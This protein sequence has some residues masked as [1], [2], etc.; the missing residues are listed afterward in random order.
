MARGSPFRFG[1]RRAAGDPLLVLAEIGWRW[2][3][4]AAALASAICALGRLL[5]TTQLSDGTLLALYSRT[6]ILIANAVA[7][8]LESAWPRLVT[9]LAILLPALAVL[10]TFASAAGRAATLKAMLD[11]SAVSMRAMFGL[12]FLRAGL[13]LAGVL[14][15]VGAFIVAGL[16][17]VRNEGSSPGAFLVVFL[18]LS[19][20]VSALWTLL[21]WYLSL[22]P[23][24]A[25]RD[26]RDTL[27]A[28]AEA[29][30]VVRRNRNAFSS[31]S[32]AFGLL[33]VVAF[34]SGTMVA[35]MPLSLVGVVRG[36]I[37][38]ALMGLAAL[39]YFALADFL[40]VARLAA[41]VRIVA[42]SDSE[43]AVS[44]QPSAISQIPA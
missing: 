35:L 31:V 42:E 13:A 12:S 28:L 44:I 25:V 34:V 36:E 21:S 24:F 30:R 22:A 41:Y 4:G 26:G 38:L 9:A 8:I 10:W 33:H 37:V 15:W 29:L 43:S 16:S 7:R 1:I 39:G 18:S 5:A 2:T 14:A 20:L 40:Y 11:R 6:P 32:G 27:A 23:L 3:F 17:A 19:F